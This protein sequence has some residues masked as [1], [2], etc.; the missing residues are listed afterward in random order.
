[1][2][3]N[4]AEWLEERFVRPSY[5]AILLFVLALCFFGAGANTM[6]GWLY[7]LSGLTIALLGLQLVRTIIW[8]KPSLLRLMVHRTMPA[9][10]NAGEILTVEIEIENN[11]SVALNMLQVSDDLPKEL[12]FI[13]NI[14]IE[15]TE[16]KYS[17]DLPS[18][19]K[20][21]SKKEKYQYLWIIESLEPKEK[22]HLICSIET[23]KRGIYHWGIIKLKTGP[24]LGSFESSPDVRKIPAKAIIYPQILQL[25]QCPIIDN[26]G[27]E[28]NRQLLSDRYYK[29]AT[30][31]IT[32]TLR[33]YRYGDPIRLIHWRTSARLGE[34]K[35][36]ELE[37]ITGGEEVII[38][39]D[40]NFR[41]QEDSFEKA[42]IVAASLYSYA[43]RRQLNVKLWLP[44]QGLLQGNR[45]VLETLAGVG[46]SEEVLTPNIP[47]T[48]SVIWLTENPLSLNSLSVGSRWIFFNSSTVR[49]TYNSQTKGL[50]VDC[51]EPL[52]RQLQ[53]PVVKN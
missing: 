25:S 21:S 46:I 26:L 50:L 8:L 22:Y 40:T 7:V 39:L 43:S 5:S 45:L 23:T 1:M 4:I 15:Q 11:T 53:S 10:V 19:P 36:R 52:E 6:A 48:N 2:K 28:Q 27:E 17:R 3:L 47:E 32:K 35:V 51:A 38:A 41:W 13:V 12:G 9:R 30:E 33:S 31:G 16:K 34:F 42:V 20:K 24:L 18:P 29:A 14:S 44:G 49:P 37:V